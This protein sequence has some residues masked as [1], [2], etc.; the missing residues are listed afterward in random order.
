MVRVLLSHLQAF[1]PS[2]VRRLDDL[3]VSNRL[4]CAQKLSK[5]AALDAERLIHEVRPHAVVAQVTPSVL[6]DFLADESR[7]SDNLVK[8]IPTTTGVLK[9]VLW[10][11]RIA[12]NNAARSPIS[13]LRC[14]ASTWFSELP[15]SEKSHV[16]LAQAIRDQTKDFKSIV[17]VVEA[18]TLAGLRKYWR[19]PVSSE[20][21]DLAKQLI[22]KYEDEVERV[23]TRTADKKLPADKPMVAV[24]AGAT[25]I[26]G[27][28]SISKI[29]FPLIRKTGFLKKP[30][31]L[32][33]TFDV[34][35][36]GAAIAL[37][38]SF[39]PSKVVAHGIAAYGAKSTSVWK[40][41]ASAQK[42]RSVARALIA[43]TERSS[44]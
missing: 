31:V 32:Q 16:L 25:A 30:R 28:S 41:A 22:N 38:K 11:I 43:F 17:A 24:G 36:K 2:S 19:T 7:S 20:V 33:I 23:G 10:G 29:F 42:I 4:V 14:M 39:G 15:M 35:P 34:Y 6:A 5:K 9:V 40:A 27:A 18:S 44:L 13:K 12:L 8:S 26:L 3:E 1:S 21:K 37:G